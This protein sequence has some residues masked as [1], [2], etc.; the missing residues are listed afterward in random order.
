[1]PNFIRY[2]TALALAAFLAVASVGIA[3]AQTGTITGRVTDGQTAQPIASA[4]VHIP[5]LNI[6]VL[7]QQNGRFILL[8][9]PAGTHELVVER[10]GYRRTTQSVTVAAGATIEQN[11]TI[12][13]EALALNEIIVTG[14][15]GGTERRAIGNVVTR[16][17]AAEV[18]E[19]AAVANMQEM[20]QARAP[21]LNFVRSSG[22]IGTGSQ[23]RIRGVSSLSLG[24]QPL[25]FVDGVRVDNT[26]QAGPAVRGGRQTSSLDDFNPNDIESIEIIKGP[27]AATLYGTEASAGV[28]QIITKKG[29]QG[30]PQ[31]DLTV[32]QGSNFMID[33]AG[34]IGDQYGCRVAT[35]PCPPD[36]LFRFNIVEHER[37]VHGNDIFRPGY[38]QGYNLGVRGGT[39]AVRYYLAGDFENQRGI[40]DYNWLRR[41]SLRGNVGVLFNERLR[42]D[43]ATGFTTGETSFMQ[44]LEQGGIWENALWAQ[45]SLLETSRRGFL[46]YT[47]EE[48]ATVSATRDNARFTGSATFTHE[49]RDLLTQRLI[50]GIDYASEE[51]QIL[52]PRHPLGA[53]GPFLAMSLGDIRNDRPLNTVTTLDYGASARYR[54]NPAVQLTTSAGLQYYSGEQNR[55]ESVGSV[56]ASPAIRSIAGATNKTVT[57]TFEQNKSMGLYVQQEAAINDRV[58]LTA[59]VRADDNSAF[60]A[61]FN[62]AIYPKLSATWVVSDEAFWNTDLVNSLRLRSAWGRAGRQPSTFAAVTIYQPIV[63]PG[64]TPA[65][66]PETFGNAN[67]GPEVS[68]ELEVGFDAAFFNDRI[69]TEATYFT[70]RVTDALLD[71]PLAP[72]FPFA[73]NQSANIGRLDNWGWELRV[74]ARAVQQRNWALDLGFSG[75]HS[76]N[77]IVSLGGRP[78]TETIREG[79]PYPI[80]VSDFL[81]HAEFDEFGRPTNL[82]CDAG[83]GKLGLYPGGERVPCAEVRNKRLVLGPQFPPY[84]WSFDGTLTLQQNLQVF[85]LVNGEF[86][87]WNSDT[88]AYCQHTLCYSNVAP[89]LLRNDPIYVESVVHSSRHPSNAHDFIRYD[90]SFWK[91]REVG[92]RY[93][94]PQRWFGGT[95]VERASLAV[96]GRNL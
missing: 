55:I 62:A 95:G 48:I 49:F 45:G 39:D 91:L 9:V 14:T 46:R 43:V 61:D 36:Q 87:R 57:Q 21:G 86:G 58:Y 52:V 70:Q 29:I 56:F 22:N 3:E 93:Q 16:V 7:T 83:T 17:N 32:H 74:D 33:P 37:E 66:R 79:L 12:A 10:I 30:A 35:R 96:S 64:G 34:R 88:N 26:G 38:N 69:S 81:V 15:P 82:L 2:R 63:G 4:Q 78:E 75:A 20:L 47:P 73:G 65:V 60:G 24:S 85:A 5:G 50:V 27:A 94:L 76:M 53:Q 68:T 6:G 89:A 41:I 11:M 71:M 19:R 23:M 18:T 1:V 80:W 13:Q 59:A 40:V 84:T 72:S 28:I 31:F 44:Q 51:N 92:A 42:L 25:I 77:E 67:V 90:A 54:L 8:N